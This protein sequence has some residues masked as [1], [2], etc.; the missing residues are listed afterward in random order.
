MLD[1][2]GL[3]PLLVATLCS[4]LREDSR[5]KMCLSGQKISTDRMLRMKIAD[6]LAFLGWAKTK[7]AQKGKNR[8]ESILQK[9]LKPRKRDEEQAVFDSAS[10]FDKAWKEITGGE[11]CQR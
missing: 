4:G 11:T 9:A 3:S 2:R 6:E 1:Y 10:A 5:V 8:P 7:D